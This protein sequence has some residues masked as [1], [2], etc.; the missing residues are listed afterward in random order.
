MQD[1]LHCDIKLHIEPLNL[2][3]SVVE[4][5]RRMRERYEAR[6]TLMPEKI[7]RIKYKQIE[8]SFLIILVEVMLGRSRCG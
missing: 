6:G 5:S 4:T 7:Q 1:L 2:L 8:Q 3:I